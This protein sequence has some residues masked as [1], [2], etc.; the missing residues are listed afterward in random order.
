MHCDK[1][2]LFICLFGGGVSLCHAGWSAVV[3]SQLT[4]TS[5]C[6]V[7]AILLLQPPK[8]LGLQVGATSHTANVCIFSVETGFHYVCQNG[9]ELLT[10]WSS[11]LGLPKCWDYR[12]EPLHPAIIY[13]YNYWFIYLEAESPACI[14]LFIF[15]LIY[16][17]IFILVCF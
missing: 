2:D 14:Y 10:L 11:C 16:L 12:R 5:A 7:Q 17:I 4:A 9:L 3:Q 8:F 1:W 15:L 6:W 13:L